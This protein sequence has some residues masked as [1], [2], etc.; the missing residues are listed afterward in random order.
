MKTRSILALAVAGLLSLAYAEIEEYDDLAPYSNAISNECW[1]L[2]KHVVWHDVVMI[3][4]DAGFDPRGGGS[5]MLS[6]IV[7]GLD[8]FQPNG[9]CWFEVMCETKFNPFP[10]VGFLLFLK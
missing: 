9:R 3:D 1:C 7:D 5:A 8:L 2:T 10:P 4:S 6:P